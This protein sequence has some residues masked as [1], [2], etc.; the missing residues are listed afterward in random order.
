MSKKLDP[1]YVRQLERDVR[2]TMKRIKENKVEK[3]KE[4]IPYEWTQA[5]GRR[6]GMAVSQW[7]TDAVSQW[8]FRSHSRDELI[9]I[10]RELE[11]GEDP[12][13]DHRM[14]G[15]TDLHH[16]ERMS[17]VVARDDRDKELGLHV[18]DGEFR[19]P[20]EDRG[21]YFEEPI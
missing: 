13:K 4:W 3:K 19:D 5:L 20:P 10:L 17:H 14:I 21:V 16:R 8:W 7:G 9:G 1:K 11:D 2:A 18:D 15:G 12:Y 6:L